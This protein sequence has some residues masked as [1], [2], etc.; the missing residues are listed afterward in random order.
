MRRALPLVSTHTVHSHNRRHN[1]ICAYVR[2]Y[3]S[4]GLELRRGGGGGGG[5]EPYSVNGLVRESHTLHLTLRDNLH[6]YTHTQTPYVDNMQRA[7]TLSPGGMDGARNVTPPPSLH[8]RD[9][10]RY[11]LVF[12]LTLRRSCRECSVSFS[13]QLIAGP[14]RFI[15]AVCVFSFT[16]RQPPQKIGGGGGGGGGYGRTFTLCYSM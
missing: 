2:T 15:I 14:H 6:R 11:G 16:R 1:K 12:S 8:L 3:C 4:I 7:L 9:T 5:G 13:D 10:N